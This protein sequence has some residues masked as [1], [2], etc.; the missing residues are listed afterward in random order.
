M[1]QDM[2]IFP[3]NEAMSSQP[4]VVGMIQ[5][6]APWST[7]LVVEDQSR[8]AGGGFPDGVQ[9]TSHDLHPLVFPQRTQPGDDAAVQSRYEVS[10]R[11]M[12]RKQQTELS[13]FVGLGSAW[14]DGIYSITIGW[15]SDQG[16]CCSDGKGTGEN[17]S[18]VQTFHARGWNACMVR[19]SIGD[20]N[21]TR[22]QLHGWT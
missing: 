5:A 18:V 4:R 3:V 6:V 14:G 7:T 17:V 2:T 9:A 15:V 8:P 11:V 21:G 1:N 13:R 22:R 10:V 20:S 19:S 16:V 12:C